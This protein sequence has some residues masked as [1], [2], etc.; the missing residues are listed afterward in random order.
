[1]LNAELVWGAARRM[2]A[3]VLLRIEDHDRERARSAYE[4]GILDD[5]DWLGF[6]PDIFPTAAFRAGACDGR[7]SNRAAVYEE[8]ARDLASRGLLYGCD[9]TRRELAG[10]PLRG[11]ERRYDGRCRTRGLAPGPGVG[12]RLRL[13]PGA[14]AFVDLALGPQV[15]D[16]AAQCGDVLI[17]DR[18]GNWTYQFAAAVDD[19][20]QSI[21]LVVRGLDLLASTGRQIRI[22]RLLGRARPAAFLHHPLIMKTPDQKV[23]KS[24]GDTGIRDLRQAGWSAR[25]VREA[26][27]RHAGALAEWL[28]PLT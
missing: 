25:M 24:D 10:L 28:S 6:A 22:A 7:Q 27:R 23:S 13:E 1:V 18:L 8:A 12:W 11:G 5:L 16:P 9:C 17:R 4:R 2:G 26:A 21:D 20:R 3:G 15:Q 19:W 14:E